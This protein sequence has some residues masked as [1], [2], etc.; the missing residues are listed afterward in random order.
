MEDPEN[1]YEIV[2]AHDTNMRSPADLMAVFA[3][4]HKRFC[5]SLRGAEVKSATKITSLVRG[6]LTGSALS[7]FIVSS[8][9][10]NSNKPLPLLLK[11]TLHLSP[12][13]SHSSNPAQQLP[14][15]PQNR[16]GA[17]TGRDRQSEQDLSPL[18]GCSY[19]PLRRLQKRQLL[20]TRVP[21]SRLGLP[22]ALVRVFQG[23]QPAASLP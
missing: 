12:T 18:H 22:Q 1:Y 11:P 23:L 17:P 8:D 4:W 6:P 10:L 7:I 9:C 15:P 20:L 3:R 13:I 19:K 2:Q 14:Q 5:P 21:A 16:H